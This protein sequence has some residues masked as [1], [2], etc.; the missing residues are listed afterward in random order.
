M[1]EVNYEEKK[2]QSL[3]DVLAQL[4]G[5][6]GGALQP[7]LVEVLAGAD[8][9]AVEARHQSERLASFQAA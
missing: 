8:R 2:Q 9:S 1:W 5:P 6:S 4:D 3:R 7:T